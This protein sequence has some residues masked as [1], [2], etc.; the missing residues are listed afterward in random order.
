MNQQYFDDLVYEGEHLTA[1]A[2]GAVRNLSDDIDHSPEGFART[3]RDAEQY[4]ASVRKPKNINPDRLDH[5]LQD[6]IDAYRWNNPAASK[7]VRRGIG[8][9]RPGR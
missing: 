9:D 1:A 5:R 3:H 7:A 2:E 4:R 8:F 6:V